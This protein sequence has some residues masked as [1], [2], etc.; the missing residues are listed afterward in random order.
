MIGPT[1]RALRK[2][3]NLDHAAL[4]ILS[5]REETTA[6]WSIVQV[7]VQLHHRNRESCGGV[8]G[9]EKLVTYASSFYASPL[10]TEALFDGL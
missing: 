1:R 8:Q 5:F 10:Y 6:R 9:I 2:M 4:R 7:Q 3:A